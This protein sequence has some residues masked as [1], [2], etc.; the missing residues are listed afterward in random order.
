M[1]GPDMDI[2]LEPDAK[3]RRVYTA[4]PIPYAYREQIKQKLDDMVAEG[5]IEPVTEPT[6]WCHPIVVV[7]K[8]IARKKID[9]RL[10]VAQLSS[11]ATSPP[12]G[13]ATQ[14]A[15]EHRHPQ[16]VYEGGRPSWLLANSTF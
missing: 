9:R 2:V 11:Q 13:H 16:V 10:E 7:D 14:P 12:Y 8:K 6:D 5:I 1:A 15:A 4:L 3:P